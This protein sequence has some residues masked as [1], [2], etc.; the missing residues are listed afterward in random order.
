MLERSPG[1]RFARV[2]RAAVLVSL[3]RVVEAAADIARLLQDDPDFSLARLARTQPF[4][5]ASER[6]RYFDLLR[7]AGMPD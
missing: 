6:D 4:M 2:L 5:D 7:Q 1:L 3:Q